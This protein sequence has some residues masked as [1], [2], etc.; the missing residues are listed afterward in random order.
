MTAR[1]PRGQCG[2]CGSSNQNCLRPCQSG[3]RRLP[4]SPALLPPVPR[5]LIPDS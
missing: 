1:R 4:E 2:V 5:P 3:L